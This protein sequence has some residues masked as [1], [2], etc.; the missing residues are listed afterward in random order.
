MNNNTNCNELKNLL[1]SNGFTFDNNNN[2][3]NKQNII[4]P[5]IIHINQINSI[6]SI[7]NLPKPKTSGMGLTTYEYVNGY[8]RVYWNGEINDINKELKKDIKNKIK[9]DCD[10][11]N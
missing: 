1:E 10:F 6:L 7:L 5:K 2:N 8:G 4:F 9:K 3:N 11:F